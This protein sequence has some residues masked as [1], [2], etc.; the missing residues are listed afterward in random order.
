MLGLLDIFQKV[1]IEIT[2]DKFEENVTEDDSQDLVL[3]NIVFWLF[4]TA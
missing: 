4:L 2:G 1:T 3:F